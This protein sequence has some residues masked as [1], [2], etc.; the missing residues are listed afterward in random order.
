MTDTFHEWNIIYSLTGS[1]PVL[2]LG[3]ASPCNQIGHSDVQ[4]IMVF[5]L[6]L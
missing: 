1:L 4:I 5:F 2:P 3:P 6:Y